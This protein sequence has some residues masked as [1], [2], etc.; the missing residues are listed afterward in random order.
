MKQTITLT[1]SLASSAVAAESQMLFNLR[2]HHLL[3]KEKESQLKQTETLAHV[4]TFDEIPVFGG[5]EF[6]QKLLEQ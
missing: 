6:R 3:N 4:Q 1:L 5:A 2:N